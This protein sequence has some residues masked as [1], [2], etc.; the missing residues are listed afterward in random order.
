MPRATMIVALLMLALGG[1]AGASSS[2][3]A[4]PP[5][6]L[7]PGEYALPT[8]Q[9]TLNGQPVACGGVG[10]AQEVTIH[11]SAADPALTWIVFARDGHREDVLWPAGYR[12]RFGPALEVLDPS[13][14]VVARE[15]ELVTGGC[16]MPPGGTYID[17]PTVTPAPSPGSSSP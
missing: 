15:G 6:S 17:L 14:A 2:A 13:G 4:P 5:P 9:T 16:P 11:G 8:F 12:A 10:Y 1:C 3:S 7:A